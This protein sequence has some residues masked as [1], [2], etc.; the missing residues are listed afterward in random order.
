VRGIA[1]FD[2]QRFAGL[3]GLS[4]LLQK[5]RSPSS[6]LGLTLDGSRLEGVVLRRTNGSLQVQKTF[7]LSL[8]L[9][10][11]T[12]DPELVGREIRNHLDAEG[13]R[14]RRC[15]LCVPVSLAL[16]L[17]TKVPDLPEA[18]RASFLQ[19][20]AERGF[21]YGPE[22]LCVATSRC[23]AASGEQHATLVAMPRSHVEQ[24]EK[25]LKA[26]QL[27]LMSFTL[28]STTLQDPDRE[29]SQGALAL[30]IG[31]NSLDLQVVCGGGV[32]ALRSLDGAVEGEGV[33]RRL[34]AD[35]IAREI[36][37]TLGQLPP[38]F[39]DAV[40]RVRVFGRGE[41]VQRFVQEIA[42]RLETMGLQVEWAKSY[43]AD[44][45]SSALPRDATVSPALSLAARQLTGVA[46]GL[47][48]LPPRVSAWQQ[49]AARVSTRKLGW[50]GLTAGGV[51]LLVALAFLVQQWQLARLGSRWAAMEPKVTELDTM[52]QQIRQFRP[53]FDETFKTLTILRKLTEA[54]PED[55][56]VTAKTVEIR[57]L[58]TVTCVGT[59][60]DMKSFLIMRDRLSAVPQVADVKVDRTGG[61][62]PLPFTFG[63]RWGESAS[64]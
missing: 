53:W 34:Y 33:Q 2:L 25:A 15:V 52:R 40:R 64:Q 47:E 45:F 10:P 51:A 19:I 28:G 41:I 1:G 48:F 63:F 31:E 17:H 4:A 24:L 30:A 46:A 22:A 9:N 3:L 29:F 55:G 16:V 5:Q 26:A 61:G 49:F 44:E 57:D 38:E 42:P 59:A 62:S 43:A 54:F 36:R 8:A 27:K 58:S 12:G 21:P 7:S 37:I 11:L 39:H 18:D 20:E 32:A 56:A 13:I 35:V 6:L 50:V 14:E 23:R 60:R